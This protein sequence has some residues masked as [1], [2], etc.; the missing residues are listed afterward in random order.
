MGF[1]GFGEKKEQ[2]KER[3]IWDIPDEQLNVFQRH[4]KRWNG[5]DV[6]VT[7]NGGKYDR[8]HKA[9]MDSRMYTNLGC[10][11]LDGL[12]EMKA[13]KFF[14]YFYELCANVYWLCK[15]IKEQQKNE[16]NYEELLAENK[17]LKQR[18]KELEASIETL[19]EQQQESPSLYTPVHRP[20]VR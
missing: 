14:L 10:S 8:T 15:Q 4:W 7:E 11:D 13:P 1:L 2:K 19:K 18:C 16:T 6:F 20:M 5:Q 17:A 3:T 9:Q 12:L